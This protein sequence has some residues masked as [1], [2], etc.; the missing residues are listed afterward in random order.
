MKTA[1]F[2][3]PVCLVSVVAWG[4]AAPPTNKT[5]TT[6]DTKEHQGNRHP[7]NQN[8][9]GEAPIVR[10]IA[11]HSAALAREM[12]YR[13]LIPADYETSGHRYP[14]LYLLHGLTG[15]YID[16]E[17]RTQLDQYAAGLPLIIAMPDG[18]D[19]WYTNSAT[20]PQEKWEDYIVKDFI[21]EIDKNYRTIQTKFGRAIG[22]LSMGGYGAMKFALKYPG[23]FIFA[24]SFS[25][26][27]SVTS[28]EFRP[29]AG[30]KAAGQIAAIFGAA[31]SETRTQNDVYT[32]AGKVT[33]PDS[34]PY[35]WISCGTEDTTLIKPNQ[36]FA[37][38]LVR[39]KIRHSYSESPGVHAWNFWDDGIEQVLPLLMDRYFRAPKSNVS[40]TPLGAG[41][42][43]PRKGHP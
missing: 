42:R 36:D 13:I 39:Q 22:G 1:R 17:T 41:P 31:D 43:T 11:F 20:Q 38:L 34:L 18:D 4:Q 7:S 16:W 6:K 40:A 29:R 12:H 24:A 33:N 19:S 28:N 21:P 25:G 8:Q 23:M 5:L 10:D 15:S 35:L 27:L 37:A 9:V 26:A 2:L 30:S 14:V 3:L 32:L